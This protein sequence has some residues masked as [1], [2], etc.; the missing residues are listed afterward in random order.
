LFGVETV[1][2]EERGKQDGCQAQNSNEKEIKSR[3]E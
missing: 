3:K 2:E 1:D